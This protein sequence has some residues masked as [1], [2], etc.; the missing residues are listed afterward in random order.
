M[1]YDIYYIIIWIIEF[2]I[3]IFVNIIFNK[4]K[5]LKYLINGLQKIH[6]SIRNIIL[7]FI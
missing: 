5:L 1:I 3:I 2:N 7:S 6:F 4:L